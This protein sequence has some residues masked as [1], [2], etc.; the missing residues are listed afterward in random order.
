MTNAQTPVAVL[1][2]N[3]ISGASAALIVNYILLDNDEFIY[4]IN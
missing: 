2:D 4:Q 1:A 3:S